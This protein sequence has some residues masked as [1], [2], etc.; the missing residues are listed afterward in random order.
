[1]V[2]RLAAAIYRLKNDLALAEALLQTKE[3]AIQTQQWLIQHQQ[4]ALNAQLLLDPVK[5]LRTSESNWDKEELMGG[6]IAISP[7]QG[8]GAHDKPA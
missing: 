8:K 6:T 5:E 2:N 3:V 4:K 1:M 7:Y